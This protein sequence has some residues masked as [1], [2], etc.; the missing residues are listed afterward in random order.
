MWI[1]EG[2]LPSSHATYVKREKP[3]FKNC[4]ETEPNAKEYSHEKMHAKTARQRGLYW[5]IF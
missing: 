5:P 3:K 2:I 1:L 4:E